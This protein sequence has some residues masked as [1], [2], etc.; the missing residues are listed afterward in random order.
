MI[1]SH[2]IMSPSSEVLPQEIIGYKAGYN[3]LHI[4]QWIN[5][6]TTRLARLSD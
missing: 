2:S 5:K 4:F 3:R 1:S 6:T